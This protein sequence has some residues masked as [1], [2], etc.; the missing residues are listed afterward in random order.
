MNENKGEAVRFDTEK[1]RFDLVPAYAHQELAKV[2]TFGARKYAENNWR[3]GMN[4]SRVIGS[5]ER[6][7]NAHKSGEDYDPE[8]GLLHSAHIMCNAAFLTE[9]YKIFPQG[10]DRPTLYLQP[11][12]IGIDI[13]DVLADFM[14]AYCER[15][16]LQR[17]N[18]WEFDSVF[19]D[20]YKALQND[21][22]FFL[23]LKTILSPEDL[24]FEPTAY[25]TSRPSN[26][27]DV[28]NR[29]LFEI[30][31]YPIAPLI[32]ASNKLPVIKEMQIERFIDDKIATFI[33]LNNNGILCYLFDSS[34]N[35]RIEVG[36]KRITKET[37]KNVL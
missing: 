26:L 31:H 37:I 16:N 24:P 32:F 1:V 4:W 19:V 17:P 18:A 6:H 5:L 13:D 36:Y 35:Q 14:G 29:W 20:R 15:Y 25:I 10:D 28:T 7:L 2:F 27:G 21:P 22:D 30:N 23:N 8:T 9:Y 12:R 34:H 33:H 3:K 11:K